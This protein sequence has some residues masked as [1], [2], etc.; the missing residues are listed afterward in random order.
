MND[1]AVAKCVT[2]YIAYRK[3]AYPRQCPY[4]IHI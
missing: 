3:A 2:G 1:V 4:L